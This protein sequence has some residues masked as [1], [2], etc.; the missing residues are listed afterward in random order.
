MSSIKAMALEFGSPRN[1]LS[2]RS[3]TPGNAMYKVPVKQRQPQSIMEAK[4]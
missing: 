1:I 2:V 4:I 3:T